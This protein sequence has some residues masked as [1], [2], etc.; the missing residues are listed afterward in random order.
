MFDR[1][2]SSLSEDLVFLRPDFTIG[3]LCSHVGASEKD[4][5][6]VFERFYRVEQSR[7]K[8]TGGSGLGLSI[9]QYIA[10]GN[11]AELSLKSKLNE[12]TTISVIFPVKKEEEMAEE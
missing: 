7:A 11:N 3:L 10:K 4:I 1:L 2:E 5:D 12:G 6:R 8:E 9:A